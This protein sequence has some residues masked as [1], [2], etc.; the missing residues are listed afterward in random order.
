MAW[1]AGKRTVSK[2]SVRAAAV[3]C[4]NALNGDGG[5][6]LPGF[7]ADGRAE[8]M[9][10]PARRPAMPTLDSKM[11]TCPLP[12]QSNKPTVPVSQVSKAY[13]RRPTRVYAAL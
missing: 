13:L 6:Q 10:G 5:T 11:P 4:G 9:P 12:F 8:P 1:H 7:S 3:P 2:Q